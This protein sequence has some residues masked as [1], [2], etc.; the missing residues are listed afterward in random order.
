MLPTL[1]PGDIVVAEVIPREAQIQEHEV[2]VSRFPKSDKILVE[3]DLERMGQLCQRH[4]EPSLAGQARDEDHW[5][6]FLHL[7][8]LPDCLLFAEKVRIDQLHPLACL[9]P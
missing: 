7:V 6:L 4:S 8:R 2:V 5:T 3:C 1:L 9:R